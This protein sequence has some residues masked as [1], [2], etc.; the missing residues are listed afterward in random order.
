MIGGNTPINLVNGVSRRVG[1][2]VYAESGRT[3]GTGY[4]AV[5]PGT[6][7]NGAITYP[8]W[9]AKHPEFVSGN[10]IVFPADVA[11]MFL[12]NTGG[13]AAAIGTFQADAT[14][15]N[16][17][18]GTTSVNGAHSHTV[19]GYTNKD[20]MNFTGNGGRMQGSDATTPYDQSTSA[21]GNHSHSLNI[22]SSDVETRPDNRAYQLYTLV[23]TYTDVAAI[24]SISM[25][26]ISAA[27]SSSALDNSSYTQTWNWTTLTNGSGLVSNANA[28]TS[29]VLHQLATSSTAF[30][31]SLLNLISA[32]NSASV[33]GSLAKLDIV[34]GTSAAKGLTINNAGTGDSL[35]VNATGSGLAANFGGAIAT[36]AGTTYTTPG[37]AND[38]AFGNASFIRL[39][40]SGAAQTITGIAGGADGKHLTLSNADASLAVTLSN[41][42][43]GSAVANRIITGT[44]SDVSIAAGASIELIYDATDTRWRV[45][46]GTGGGGNTTL[47][48]ISSNSSV[49]NWNYSVKGDASS[50]A[51]T[52]T[53]PTAAGNSGKLI[54]V[55]RVDSSTNSLCVK[56]F[57]S[58]TLNSSTNTVCLY[59]Q[60]DSIV[61]RSDGTNVIMVADNRSSAGAPSEY[62]EATDTSFRSTSSTSFVDATGLSVTLPSAG[63]Y[64]IL[65]HIDQNA[66]DPGEGIEFVVTDASNNQVAGSLS[67]VEMSGSGAY[68]QQDANQIVRVTVTSATTYKLRWRS[69]TGAQ[70]DYNWG[71]E[72]GVSKI[73]YKK[74]SSPSMVTS[75]VDYV[76]ATQATNQ[77]PAVGSAIDYTANIQGNIAH[78]GSGRYRL[79]AGKTYKLSAAWAPPNNGGA[80]ADYQWY[81]VTAG[82]YIGT[83]GSGGD[84]AGAEYLH[85]LATAIITPTADTDVEVRYTF[86]NAGTSGFA[87]NWMEITQIGTTGTTMGTISTTDYAYAVKTANQAIGSGGGDVAFESKTGS[88]SMPTTSTFQL[89]AGKTYKLDTGLWA[90][91]G[92][93][94]QF[95]Y[96]WVDAGT[97]TQLSG[98]NTG[99]INEVG[100]VTNGSST[101]LTAGGIYTPVADQTVKVRLTAYS[102][103]NVSIKASTANYE[104]Q[105]Y[106]S[107]VQLGSTVST[108]VA[109]SYITNALSSGSLDNGNYSQT[110][111]WSTLTTTTGLSLTYNALTSGTG[112]NIS[113]S[114]NSLNSSTGLL[115]INNS[116]SST[117]GNVVRI[118]ASSTKQN[119]LVVAANGNV[120][121][122]ATGPG[123]TL[124]VGGTSNVTGVASFGFSGSSAID[125]SVGD[126]DTGLEQTSDGQLEIRTN[127]GARFKFNTG[128]GTSFASYDGDGNI[129]FGSDARLKHDVEDSGA[130]LDKVLA[131]KVKNFYYN[132]KDASN[133]QYKDIGLIAQEVQPLFPE[134][135]GSSYSDALGDNALTVAY[136]DLGTIGIKAI[137]ELN[138]KV[139]QNK[140]EIDGKTVGGLSNLQT[141][142]NSLTAGLSVVQGKV[143]DFSDALA[144]VD[145]RIADLDTR[146]KVMES[147][148]A[149]SAVSTTTQPSATTVNNT[150]QQIV[151]STSQYGVAKV[152]KGNVDVKVTFKKAYQM[153][154]AVFVTPINNGAIYEV[155]EVT[156]AGFTMKLSDSAKADSRFN[157]M[158][159]DL[160]D[161]GD[162]DGTQITA[163][164]PTLPPA[165]VPSNTE[166]SESNGSQNTQ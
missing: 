109:M 27:V 133:Q 95:E 24:G 25:S 45:V 79:V 64:E 14:A 68:A 39:D 78:V 146:L 12:R 160:K 99:V 96:A 137:Q 59:N 4:L 41:Q 122:G 53:L 34:G 22:T 50:T 47:Q 11:G 144:N 143:T 23:D 91:D 120:G 70:V 111:N 156:T 102:G 142:V 97:N 101:S 158:A 17:L 98:T 10:N 90:T 71:A 33:T 86:D 16:G 152:L 62:G 140:V 126:S 116:G 114:S 67:R 9:A 48:T 165:T 31:G 60:Y 73:T 155:S 110:W 93:G 65:Y 76:R 18:G 54:E 35:Q 83:E 26:A 107:V 52:V 149:K 157:W 88:L 121:I 119:A 166:S 124:T 145:L 49:S 117:S 125:L 115:Y 141:Q 57:G 103:S 150:T 58:E 87:K 13:N 100:S 1:E 92:N 84:P 42:S 66:P 37:S 94:Q 7:T 51:V 46:G 106:A 123:S 6:I 132:G 139:D 138:M 61:V 40:T 118:D 82:A 112:M 85:G 162:D 55:T 2:M 136:T 159:A 43:T 147:A 148:S 21:D 153:V 135:V 130:V 75:T 30:T 127:G 128:N 29:G 36:K 74:I 161:A 104:G 134:L 5:S 56:A 20:D 129:D 164:T 108:G 44:G 151:E 80:N 113:T 69:A 131:L 89:I 15:V 28:L 63:T 3:V 77:N 38:V 19:Y 81:N 105:S 8:A 154:P 32:G 163:P 72:G